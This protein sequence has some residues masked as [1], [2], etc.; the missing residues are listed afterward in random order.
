LLAGRRVMHITHPETSAWLVRAL[1]PPI[2]VQEC[3]HLF[4]DYRFTR[5]G[6]HIFL[7]SE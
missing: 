7:T 4:Q 3:G 6:F 5:K 1:I 2:H